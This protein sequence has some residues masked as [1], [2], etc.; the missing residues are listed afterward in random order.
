MKRRTFLKS[1][2][3]AMVMPG[4]PELKP[5]PKAIYTAKTV[6]Y[7]ARMALGVWFAEKLEEDMINALAGLRS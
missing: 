2:V 7:D 3:A 1:V 6:I 5:V 4:L